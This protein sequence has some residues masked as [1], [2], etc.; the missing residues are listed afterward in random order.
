MMIM[1]AI[2]PSEII[3][4]EPSRPK[5]AQVNPLIRLTARLFDYSLFF[6]VIRFVAG[7][8]VL[9]LPLE[10]W[11]TLEF[12]AWVPFETLLLWTWGTTPGKWLLKTQIQKGFS[13]RLDFE[14]ALRRSF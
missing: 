6:L 10:N 5:P 11:I 12:F 14:T 13:K 9:L 3:T 4:G 8:A 2:D 1:E 7:S